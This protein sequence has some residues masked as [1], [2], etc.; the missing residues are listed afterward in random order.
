MKEVIPFVVDDKL[1]QIASKLK[2]RP[3]TLRSTLKQAEQFV[4]SGVV[5]NKWL[6]WNTNADESS[7][8]L[9]EAPVSESPENSFILEVERT[10]QNRKLQG[11]SFLA[12]MHII[13]LAEYP[14][15]VWVN[16]HDESERTWWAAI[17]VPKFQQDETMPPTKVHEHVVALWGPEPK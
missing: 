11:E 3:K 14:T 7:S 15:A 6:Y 1:H 4:K 2:P 9:N 5:K 10:M 13:N 8:A 16:P 17:V 12:R